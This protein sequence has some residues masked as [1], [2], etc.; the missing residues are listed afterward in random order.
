MSPLPNLISA[1]W[2]LSSRLRK[3]IRYLCAG[4]TAAGANL[5]ILFVL[6]HY[7]ELYYL[8]ASVIGV[9]SSM[10]LG[11]ALQKFW[12]FKDRITN[13]MHF[14]FLGYIIISG[15]NL[16]INTGL[17]YLFVSKLGIWYLAAQVLAGIVIAITGYIG[18]QHFVF[19]PVSA[20]Q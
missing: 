19:K 14:Q 6:V 13:R 17:M 8:T 15:M 7:F 1:F 9:L 11:F 4:T 18:Y 5:L 3:L 16:V 2:P 12:T 10:L 20:Q